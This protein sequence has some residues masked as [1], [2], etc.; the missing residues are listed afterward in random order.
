MYALFRDA[1]STARGQALD[2]N[3][4]YIRRTYKDLIGY[5]KGYYRKAPKAVS[6]PNLI[7]DIIQQFYIDDT[8]DD[9][10]WSMLVERQSLAIARN[11][12]LGSAL[13]RGKVFDKGITLG[14]ECNELAMASFERI[15]YSSTNTPWIELVPVK[16]LYH[17]RTDINLPV[18]SNTTKGKGHGVIT[19]NIPM[20]LVQYRYWLRAQR[21]RGVEQYENAYRFVGSIV[22]P[23]ML[24][25]YLDIAYFNRL[26]RQAQGIKNVKFPTAHPFYLTDLTDKVDRF[27]TYVND[28][29]SRKGIDP[30]SLAW[31]TPALVKDNLFKVMALP[32]EPLS[33][34][35]EWIYTLARFPYVKYLILMLKKNPG[36]DRAQVN[37]ILI[38]LINARTDSIFNTMGSTEFIKHFKKESEDLIKLIKED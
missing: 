32:R 21:A 8:V 18:M 24:E 34:Q 7:A 35:N 15:N 27:I 14:P 4:I 1:P 9:N 26:A 3:I 22:L 38:E 16:Y 12:G 36:Y 2:P 10:Q 30:E 29:N 33:Y 11:F 19:I 25:S 37:E 6:S 20:L 5:V 31:I 28:E 23:N 17:T 13:F